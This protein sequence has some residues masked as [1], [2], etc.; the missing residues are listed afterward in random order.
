MNGLPKRVIAGVDIQHLELR[1]ELCGAH[2]KGQVHRPLCVSLHTIK[3]SYI[4]LVVLQFSEVIPQLFQCRQRAYIQTRSIIYQ[5]M[6]DDLSTAYHS[7]V[8]SFV[9]GS[10]FGWQL[11]V[12]EADA[13][14]LNDLMNHDSHIIAACA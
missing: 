4:N 14:P 13:V 12:T 7:D 10:L 11:I 5:N 6:I 8:Q 9:M 1:V 2:L 3:R